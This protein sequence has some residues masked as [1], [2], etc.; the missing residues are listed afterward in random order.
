MR[1]VATSDLHLS[2][3][4]HP[5]VIAGRNARA[6]DVERAWDA[7]VQHA[8]DYQPDLFTVAGDC[9]DHPRPSMHALKAFQR[10]IM[11]VLRETDAHVVVIVGNH[12]GS[13]TVEALS[14]V[15]VVDD[16]DKRVHVVQ[17][18][19]RLVLL[20][21]RTGERCAIDCFPFGVLGQAGAHELAPD[22]SADVSM[23]L[24]HAAVRS[25]ASPAAVP[26]FYAGPDKVDVGPFADQY[27][28]IACGDFH[29]FRRLHPKRLAFYSGSVE[30]T[31]SNIWDEPAPKGVV[32]YDTADGSLELLKIPTRPMHDI[33]YRGTP[34]AEG[35]NEA[36]A[37]L[38]ER[39]YD[40]V[41]AR[42][43]VED[44][45]REERDGLDQNLVRNLRNQCLHFDLTLRYR[46]SQRQEVQARRENIA[47]SLDE[48]CEAF[49]ADDPQAVRETA[50]EFMS[51]AGGTS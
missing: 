47:R 50:L 24:I 17:Q 36:L 45:P 42:L 21:H 1:G 41:M 43:V 14:P 49:M 20:I 46:E 38:V 40:G 23:L 29:E 18:P 31:S 13:R 30:R 28:V 2:F 6:V 3:T 9:F 35:V 11:T 34:T 39:D 8:V 44:F 5:A 37:L 16:L 4:R 33:D 48:E 7:A 25:S 10:G 22:P 32:A 19:E 27:D 51:A 12:E 15:V 26:S